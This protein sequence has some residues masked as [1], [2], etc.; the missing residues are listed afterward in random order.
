MTE[1]EFVP[2][3]VKPRTKSRFKRLFSFF[4]SLVDEDL[5]H[6]DA[7]KKLLEFGERHRRYLERKRIGGVK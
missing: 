6:D 3:W 1:K 5:K 4:D 7:M 2:I